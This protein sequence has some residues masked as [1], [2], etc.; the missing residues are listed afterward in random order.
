V[1]HRNPLPVL[2]GKHVPNVTWGKMRLETGK[3][4][5]PSVSH[6]NT[7]L[8]VFKRGSGRSLAICTNLLLDK[9]A[10]PQKTIQPKEHWL[11][12]TGEVKN[13]NDFMGFLKLVISL[14]GSLCRLYLEFDSL[15]LYPAAS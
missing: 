3:N 1:L 9:R 15:L 7:F 6:I 11:V 5:A 10:V 12:L 14:A 4:K 2:D 13:S 8:V